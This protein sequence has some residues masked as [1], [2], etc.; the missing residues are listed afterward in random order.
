MGSCY[1]CGKHG[2]EGTD[3]KQIFDIHI[4]ENMKSTFFKKEI[5]LKGEFWAGPNIPTIQSGL[6]KKCM[7]LAF[8]ECA[9]ALKSEERG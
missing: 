6:C 3:L 9:Q 8:Q 5:I 2:E 1:Y 4:K 7:A